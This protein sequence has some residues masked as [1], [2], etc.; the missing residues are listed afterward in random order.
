MRH[1]IVRAVQLVAR[2]GFAEH[3]DAAVVFGARHATALARDESTLQVARVA[4]RVV[5]GGAKNGYAA[6]LFAPPQDPVVRD[7]APEQVSAVAEPDGTFGPAATRVQPLDCRCRNAVFREA[8]VENLDTRIGI[9]RRIAD[10]IGEGARC[11]R[12]GREP[13]DRK[14]VTSIDVHGCAPAVVVAAPGFASARWRM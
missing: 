5:C 7:V 3:G 10:R 1:D 6:R 4:V 14:H 12:T 13:T 11:E 2:N 8:C 9:S